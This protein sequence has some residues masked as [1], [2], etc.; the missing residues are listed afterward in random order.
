MVQPDTTANQTIEGI[1]QELLRLIC[2]AEG[3]KRNLD[4][5]RDLFLPTAQLT[6]LNHD[7]DL[8]MPAETVSLDEFME[9]LEDPY[10]DEGFVEYE[11]GK[12]IN[13]YNGIANVFQSFHAKD[14]EGSEARGISSYQ[15]IYLQNRWWI[16]HLQWTT[17]D[18][19]VS[20]P[21]RYLE[22]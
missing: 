5:V 9:Y 15:L 6:V 2:S 13:E 10:Y 16:T 14:I 19:G 4:A 8:S 21:G 22:P 11:I 17:D 7:D 20:V 3:K 18:N 1:V 12:V